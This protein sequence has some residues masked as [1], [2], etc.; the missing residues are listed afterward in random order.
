MNEVKYIL[1]T[2]DSYFPKLIPKLPNLSKDVKERKVLKYDLYLK[3]YVNEFK[4]ECTKVSTIIE[5][6]DEGRLSCTFNSTTKYY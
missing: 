3:V 4:F 2:I 6:I 5:Q 1:K